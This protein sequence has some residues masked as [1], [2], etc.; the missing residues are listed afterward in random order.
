[1]EAFI[2]YIDC[3][4]NEPQEIPLAPSAEIQVCAV[5]DSVT[6]IEGDTQVDNLGPCG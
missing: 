2:S 1:M 6:T 3:V 5:T 4:S